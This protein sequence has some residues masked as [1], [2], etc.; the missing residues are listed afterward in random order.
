VGVA[1]LWSRTLKVWLIS[2]FGNGIG[3][4]SAVS[5][6]VTV[7]LLVFGGKIPDLGGGSLGA[8]GE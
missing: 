7:R 2:H 3:V 5:L 6:N 1:V 4:P 8:L